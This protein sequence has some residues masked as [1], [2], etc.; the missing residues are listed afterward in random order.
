MAKRRP[1]EELYDLTKDPH[2]M[3]NLALDPG[4]ATKLAEL[5]ESLDAWIKESGDLGGI[6]EAD[7]VDMDALMREKRKY[8]ENGMTRRGLEPVR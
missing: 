7:S 6:N 3:T 2:E 1:K 8:F 4:H 5:R